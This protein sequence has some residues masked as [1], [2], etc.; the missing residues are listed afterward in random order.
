[1]K[2]YTSVFKPL[3][4]TEVMGGRIPA[5]AANERAT[6]ARTL[7]MRPTVSPARKDNRLGHPR[8]LSS[9]SICAPVDRGGPGGGRSHLLLPQLRSQRQEE[10]IL[11]TLLRQQGRPRRLRAGLVAGLLLRDGLMEV[12]EVERRHALLHLFRRGLRVAVD[13]LEN[14]PAPPHGRLGVEVVRRLR[15]VLLEHGERLL[16]LRDVLSEALRPHGGDPGTALQPLAA[17]IRERLL[18]GARQGFRR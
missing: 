9:P 1:M 14:S 4:G 7:R 17:G 16:R 8:A 6:A 18:V 2:L 5:V 3:P 10:R 11:R 12:A 15:R 13:E